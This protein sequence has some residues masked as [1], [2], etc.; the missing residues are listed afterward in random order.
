MGYKNYRIEKK[1]ILVEIP[2]E[3]YGQIDYNAE[4]IQLS[5]R[6][7]QNQINQTFLHELVHGICEKIG[8]N[9]TNDDDR[10]IDQFSAT[11]YE[12]IKDNPHIFIMK[13]I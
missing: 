3:L 2:R 7:G 9:E 12:I 5:T 6:F 4:L 13:D 8:Y 11:L 10:F 1:E